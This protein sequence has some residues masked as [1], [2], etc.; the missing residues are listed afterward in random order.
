MI[1]FIIMINMFLIIGNMLGQI[2]LIQSIP[3]FELIKTSTNRYKTI[4]WILY[5]FAFMQ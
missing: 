4:S 2:I 5:L 3:K 1:K